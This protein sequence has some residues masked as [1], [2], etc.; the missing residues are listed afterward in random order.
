MSS[1]YRATHGAL[2]RTVALKLVT[3]E[4][5]RDH[6]TR[7]RFMHEWRAAAAL[8]HPNILPVHDAGEF[9]GHLF[10]ATELVEGGDLGR[11][12]DQTG[13][14][15][16]AVA[17]P[18][19]EQVAGALDAAHAAGLVHRDVKPGNVLLDGDHAYLADFGLSRSLGAVAR[20]TAPGRMVG[21]A[22]YV[23]PEQIRGEEID[24]RTDQYAL[25]CMVFDA[26]TAAPAFEGDS[27]YILMFSHLE[28]EVPRLSD[29]LKS[30]PEAA[31]VV[32]A[33]AMAKRRNDRYDSAG[34]AVAALRESFGL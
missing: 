22:A 19:L 6:V 3:G 30:I 29:R 34:E 23:A 7:E 12:I 13:P 1:V 21:T 8:R 26:L 32:V 4:L 15:E 31:D 28:Q 33:R 20:L 16:P 27:D 10:M 14:L 2:G 18:I 17:L 24:G 11:L 25:G 9:D 5:A